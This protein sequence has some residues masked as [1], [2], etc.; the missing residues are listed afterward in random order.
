[1]LA[2]AFV[3]A[4]WVPLS[5]LDHSIRSQLNPTWGDYPSFGLIK[6]ALLGLPCWLLGVRLADWWAGTTMPASVPRARLNIW[7][8]RSGIWALSSLALVL[9]FHSPIGYPWTLN[10]FAIACFFWLQRE[11][12]RYFLVRPLR[13]LEWGGTW[14][15][16]IYLVHPVAQ[17]AWLT[18][19][20]SQVSSPLGS[21]IMLITFIALTSYAFHLVVEAPSHQLAK[22]IAHHFQR[23]KSPAV[24]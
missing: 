7:L 9:R 23:L 6:N 14:S 3:L 15:Y 4:L 21:W 24:Q 13:L 5:E 10:L 17:V 8:W 12:V 19:S 1:M 16:S 11:L 18:V 22:R 2:F 20:A